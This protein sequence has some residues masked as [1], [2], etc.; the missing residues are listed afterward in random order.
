MLEAL[1]GT[2]GE[3]GQ[4]HGEVCGDGAHLGLAFLYVCDCWCKGGTR[5]ELIGHRKSELRV[6]QTLGLACYLAGPG[7]GGST[8]ADA[9]VF[10][11]SIDE[12]PTARLAGRTAD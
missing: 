2:V 8:T 10:H 5:P 1:V 7:G 9:E 3:S 12:T 11:F 6:R 4:C